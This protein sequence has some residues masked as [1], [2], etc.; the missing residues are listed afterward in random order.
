MN[1]FGDGLNVL[2]RNISSHRLEF[3]QQLAASCCVIFPA[4]C[5]EELDGGRRFLGIIRIDVFNV[6]LCITKTIAILFK[7]IN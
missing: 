4:S 7:Y 3:L 5:I 1:C 2:D 6:L